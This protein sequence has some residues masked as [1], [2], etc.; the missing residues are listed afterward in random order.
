MTVT[1]C[2]HIKYEASQESTSLAY[3]HTYT[4]IQYIDICS[5]S[6]VVHYFLDKDSNLCEI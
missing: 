2:L 1:V 6:Y 4:Y 3:T 5:V